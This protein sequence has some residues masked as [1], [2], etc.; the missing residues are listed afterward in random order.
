VKP[1]ARRS[2]GSASPMTAKTAGLAM[3]CHAIEKASP[4]KT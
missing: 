3:L 1:I 4:T 2:R